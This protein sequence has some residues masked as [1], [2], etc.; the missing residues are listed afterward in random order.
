MLEV[1]NKEVFLI[2]ENHVLLHMHVCV[3]F[4]SQ[5]VQ[6]MPGPQ[7]EHAWYAAMLHWLD[8]CL[9]M[10][11]GPQEDFLGYASDVTTGGPPHQN[12]V[13]LLL[14]ANL[15]RNHMPLWCKSNVTS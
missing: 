4:Y 5:A 6:A 12:D 2:E 9:R 10:A 13:L 3:R 8:M 11:S 15:L 1:M 7:L 14:L